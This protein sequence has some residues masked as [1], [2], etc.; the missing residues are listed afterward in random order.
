MAYL[1]FELEDGTKVFIEANDMQKSAPG[2]L[3]SG[4]GESGEKQAAQFEQEISGVRKM[5][6]ALVKQFRGAVDDQPSDVDISFGLKASG[7]LGGFLV[8]RA[9]ADASISVTLHWRAKDKDEEKKG[10]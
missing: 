6:G 8:S 3:P 7:E 4:R 9:G 5:A 1:T 2:L 10:E